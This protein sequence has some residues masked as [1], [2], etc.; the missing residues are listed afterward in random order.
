MPVIIEDEVIV[1]GNC[2][3]YEGTIVKR[4]AVLGTGTILNRSTPVYDL[5]RGEVLCR[6]RRSAAGYSRKG[7]R[8]RR[9][10]SHFPRARQG[11]GA[12]SVHA[13]DREVSRRQN[14]PAH[15]TRRPAALIGREAIER[16]VR[17]A[18]PGGRRTPQRAACRTS[19]GNC[20]PALSAFSNSAAGLRPVPEFSDQGLSDFCRAVA[21]NGHH[22]RSR[23]AQENPSQ[24]PMAERQAFGD[25]RNQRAAI[26]LVQ[27]VAEQFRRESPPEKKAAASS[28]VRCKLCTTTLRE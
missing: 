2:G 4:G 1:G 28:A 25:A 3:V 8:G 27:P 12:F 5:V 16:S 7:R 9:L 20:A 17:C 19:D 24:A 26:G 6:E 15:A 10:A 23:S 11:M 13:G 14:R 18:V 21:R 22:R